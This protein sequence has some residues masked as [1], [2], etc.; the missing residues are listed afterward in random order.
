ME[1]T[2]QGWT[3][4]GNVASACKICSARSQSKDRTCITTQFHVEFD[5]LFETV[6]L[7][8]GNRK[9]DSQWQVLSGLKAAPKNTPISVTPP[10]AKGVAVEPIPDTSDIPTTVFVP[11]VGE[12]VFP[13]DDREQDVDSTPD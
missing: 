1:L 9:V 12:Q 10:G 3:L 4:P 11:D 7:K 2:C 5:H 8:S 6:S 13:S